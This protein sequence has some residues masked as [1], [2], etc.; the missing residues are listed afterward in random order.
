[1][2]S[3]VKS[4]GA[5]PVSGNSGRKKGDLAED[6]VLAHL[7]SKDYQLLE[8]NFNCRGG[9]LDLVM[10]IEQEIVFVEVR[11][12]Q[13]DAFGDGIESVDRHKQRKLRIAAETW[14]QNNQSLTFRG[15]RFDVV[16]VTGIAPDFELDW[17]DDAF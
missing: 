4:G 9:E 3:T 11:Y 8:R 14:L 17:I 10:M 15:C 1:M 2:N 6:Y 12:R 13:H 16:S 5:Q 7:Q